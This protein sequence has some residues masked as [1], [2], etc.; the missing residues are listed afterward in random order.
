MFF[1]H[2]VRQL[3]QCFELL[4]LDNASAHIDEKDGITVLAMVS[5]SG[6]KWPLYFPA[7]GKTVQ[8]ETNQLRTLG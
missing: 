3:S 2:V 6:I 1:L 8:V 5:A 4:G 7:T